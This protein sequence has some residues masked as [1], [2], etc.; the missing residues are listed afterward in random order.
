M[1]CIYSPIEF[2][3]SVV[4]MSY[5]FKHTELVLRSFE[6]MFHNFS[7]T[8]ILLVFYFLFLCSG[9]TSPYVPHAKTFRTVEYLSLHTT[10]LYIYIVISVVIFKLIYYIII[11][12][13]CICLCLFELVQ[14]IYGNLLIAWNAS[15]V[16]NFS[17]KSA[18]VTFFPMEVSL[19]QNQNIFVVYIEY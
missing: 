9:V 17:P 4:F 14:K 1:K 11:S 13:K 19:R 8:N 16:I 2:N 15:S 18:G 6:V 7:K 10:V 12:F 5:P 3:L